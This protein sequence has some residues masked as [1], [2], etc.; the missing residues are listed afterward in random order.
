MFIIS[1]VEKNKED[2]PIYNFIESQKKKTVRTQKPS[3]PPVQNQGLGTI[4]QRRIIKSPPK[5]N[6]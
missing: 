2:P 1:N 5:N 6:Y 3:N 4:S